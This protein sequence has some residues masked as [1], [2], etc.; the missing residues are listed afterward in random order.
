MGAQTK[1]LQSHAQTKQLH[2]GMKPLHFA[3][4][5]SLAPYEKPCCRAEAAAGAA[6]RT[7]AEA[8]VCTGAGAGAGAEAGAGVEAEAA[9][10]AVAGA[11]VR[12]GA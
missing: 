4:S 9:A 2:P 12:T 5:I 10:E 8:G 1:Q 11:A 7:G 3:G 6:I